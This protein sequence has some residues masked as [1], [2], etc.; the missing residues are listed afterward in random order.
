VSAVH[1][2]NVEMLH[3][4]WVIPILAAMTL[5]AY[6]RRRRI[7]EAIASAGLLKHINTSV[8]NTRRAWKAV[9]VML[10][11]A[12]VVL[13][14]V[15]PG[16]NPKPRTIERSGRDVVFVL[17]V[18]K[19]MLAED[20]A[21]NRLERAKLAITDCTETLEGDRVGLVAFAGTAA[22]KCPLTLDYGFFRLMLEDVS[23]DS[24]ARGGTM[25]GDAIRKVLD[26]MF[27]DREKKFKDI[28][29]I[30]DGEDHDSFPVRAA[31]EAGSRGV[32]II[33]VGL[34]DE[35]QGKRIPV[36]DQ[37]GNRTFLKYNGQEVWSTLD[38]DALRAMAIATPGGRYMPV[39]TG[40]IDLGNVY[41]ELIASAEKKDLESRTIKRYEEK[42]QI[43][44][45]VAF[46]ALTLETL[47]TERRKRPQ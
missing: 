35:N 37:H 7:L 13:A 26:E 46:A 11:A 8:S 10:A 5:Y 47:M 2:E 27:D 39:A 29:L 17:D 31:E 43:F 42:F 21:P 14:L 22:V 15:R 30:T 3:L 41:Q 36:T 1:L 28:I 33:A 24:V 4:L 32:R 20:L 9:V 38:A 23:T 6:Y 34:G 12:A 45:A 25:I 44:I 18:S 16:W 19:S 40:A